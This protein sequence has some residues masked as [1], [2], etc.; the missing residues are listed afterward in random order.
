MKVHS[1]GGGTTDD[2]THHIQT[3]VKRKPDMIIVHSGTND[4]T[5]NVDTCKH[6]DEV[7]RIVKQKLPE[8]KIA[9]S[10]VTTRKDRK[11]IDVKIKKVNQDLKQIAETYK[12]EYISNDNV[13]ERGLSQGKLHLN[14][15]GLNVLTRNFLSCMNQL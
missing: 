8:T 12:V 9:I 7:V 4:L 14:K 2:M 6:M 13:N 15:L 3:F 11:N 10:S 5:N 1:H